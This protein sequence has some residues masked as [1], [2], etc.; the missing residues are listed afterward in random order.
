MEELDPRQRRSS[1][2]RPATVVSPAAWRL[3]GSLELP[4][5]L[6]AGGQHVTDLAAVV[7]CAATT[8]P[9][10]K[11]REECHD[12]ESAGRDNEL[13]APLS[14][15]A[16]RSGERR[17]QPTTNLV[18]TE[19]GQRLDRGRAGHQHQD[20]HHQGEMATDTAT[21]L[22]GSAGAHPSDRTTSLAHRVH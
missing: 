5:P 18:G 20:R 12:D 6:S 17:L 19:L 21:P 4:L 10:P 14:A 15:T 16:H 11:R 3:S 13:N 2:E 1:A 22:A 7:D 8:T 9:P